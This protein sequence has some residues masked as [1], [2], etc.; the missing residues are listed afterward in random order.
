MGIGGSDVEVP[1]SYPWQASLQQFQS[2]IC[3]LAVISDTWLVTAAHCVGSSPSVLSVVVGMHDRSLNQ[4]S[5]SRFSIKNIIAHPDWTMDG[6]KGFPNDIAVVEI[7]GKMDLSSK[8][9]K[10]IEMAQPSQDFIGA[11]CVITGWGKT[12]GGIFDPAA[13]ILQ[14]APVEVYTKSY[15]QS[16]WST[17]PIADYHICVGDKGTAGAC[18]G[19]SGGPLACT[20][21]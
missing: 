14:E 8:Y 16:V 5:P 1:G 13:N 9:V 21:S 20:T 2:H 10:A 6:S 3:G 15:C 12:S 11:E 18:S 4:G 17:I 19:D 7:Q